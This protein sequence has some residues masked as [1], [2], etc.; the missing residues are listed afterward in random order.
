MYLENIFNLS[1]YISKRFPEPKNKLPNKKFKKMSLE[2]MFS[3]EIMLKLLD[4]I[5]QDPADILYN[6]LIYYTHELNNLRKDNYLMRYDYYIYIRVITIMKN[7][8]ERSEK[9]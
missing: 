3:N 1:N 9:I 2:Y 7:Y 8:I 4:S 6:F 5:N